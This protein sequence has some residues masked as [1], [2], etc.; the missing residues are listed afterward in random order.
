MSSFEFRIQGADELD[1]ALKAIG[2]EMERKIARSAVRAGAKVIADRAR[3]LAPEGSP[4]DKWGKN[5]TP[6]TLRRS[7]Q[8]VTRSQKTGDAVASVVTRSGKKWQAKQMDAWYAPLVEFGTE[9]MQAQPFM[10]LALDSKYRE[11]IQ[12][13]S[14]VIQ[15]RIRKAA[16]GKAR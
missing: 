13:M 9:K 4:D 5:Y 15:K 16:A 6:G 2:I 3:E 8:V 11:A 7:I 1:A 14:E 12:R 10:R